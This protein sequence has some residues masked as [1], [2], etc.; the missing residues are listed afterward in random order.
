VTITQVAFYL[1]SNNDG[2][3]EPGTDTLL[4]YATQTSPGVWTLTNNSAFGLIAGT[5]RLFTQAQDN[6]G[7]PGE[8]V[9]LALTVQ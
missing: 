7:V 6:Y 9:A 2:T 8:P 5:Y 4:D 1:D 3:L